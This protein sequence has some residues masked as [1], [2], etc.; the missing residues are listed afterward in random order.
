MVNKRQ[1]FYI[2]KYGNNTT[3]YL[4]YKYSLFWHQTKEDV[5]LITVKQSTL[6]FMCTSKD[7]N[8]NGLLEL[9]LMTN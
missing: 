8:N 2:T 5:S 1:L 4:Q 9:S 7:Y 6:M 3:I